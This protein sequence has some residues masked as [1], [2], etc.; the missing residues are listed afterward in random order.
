MTGEEEPFALEM[1]TFYYR[2]AKMFIYIDIRE[3]QKF[4]IIFLYSFDVSRLFRT[5]VPPPTSLRFLVEIL[6]N[7]F[8][9]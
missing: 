9:F 4:V 7:Y 2:K 3:I 5:F 1:K 6:F 8:D